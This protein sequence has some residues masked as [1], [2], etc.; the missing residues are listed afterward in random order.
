M[1]VLYG[2]I[3]GMYIVFVNKVRYFL[4]FVRNEIGP[5]EGEGRGRVEG[6]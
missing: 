5:G 1:C 6:G 2:K 3:G 4:K